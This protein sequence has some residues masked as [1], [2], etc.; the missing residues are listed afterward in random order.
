MKKAHVFT[1]KMW[2]G[3]NHSGMIETAVF[4]NKKAAKKTRDNLLIELINEGKE[5]GVSY[6][7]QY[8]VNGD[9]DTIWL[10]DGDGKTKFNATI[11]TLELKSKELRY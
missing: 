3:S 7:D 9:V 10:K 5:K 2:F 6:E 4:S 11:T 1:V 8:L